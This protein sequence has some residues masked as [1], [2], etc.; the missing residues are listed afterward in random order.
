MCMTFI[1]VDMGQ[2]LRILLGHGLFRKTA[3][4][5]GVHV[6]LA[7]DDAQVEAH[8]AHEAH[9]LAMRRF[10]RGDG[11]DVEPDG[12]DHGQ[13]GDVFAALPFEPGAPSCILAHT[14]K[15]KGVSFMENSVLWHYRTARGQEYDAALAELETATHA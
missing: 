12:H 2:P 4:P 8:V 7:R 11:K 15:G 10:G 9:G 6:G 1:L 5:E 13:L 14:T 3:I